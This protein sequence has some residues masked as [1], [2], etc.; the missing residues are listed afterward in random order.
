MGT[1]KEDP[2][3]YTE[4]PRIFAGW[5]SGKRCRECAGIFQEMYGA[6]Q[7]YGK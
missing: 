3:G 4:D 5:D 1:L 7:E 2:E 6:W